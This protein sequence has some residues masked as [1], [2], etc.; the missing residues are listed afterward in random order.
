ML[1]AIY[2]SV[3]QC[4]FSSVNITQILARIGTNSGNVRA[5]FNHTAAVWLGQ[6]ATF[7]VRQP[8]VSRA[9]HG[10]V[11]NDRLSTFINGLFHSLVH[12]QLFSL[13][14]TCLCLLTSK[15]YSFLNKTRSVSAWVA[16][17]SM[18]F[19]WGIKPGPHTAYHRVREVYIYV[20]DLNSCNWLT[21][22]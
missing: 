9:H 18:W 19:Q 13:Y 12:C 3:L 11:F 1:Y 8:A 6:S 20:L 7:R 22:I 10:P 17:I 2:I 16:L 5:G 15:G 14:S 4:F 21:S